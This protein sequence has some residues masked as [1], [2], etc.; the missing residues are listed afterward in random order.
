MPAALTANDTNYWKEWHLQKINAPSAWDVSTG[1]AGVVIAI[2]DSGIDSTHPDLAAKI[3]AGYNA[4]DNNSDTSDV[5]GHGTMVA[6]SAG[7]IS[8]NGIGVASVAWQNPLMPIRVTDTQGNGYASTIAKGLTWA[9]DHGARVMNI[10]FSGIAASSTITSAAQYVVGKGGIVVAASGNCGCADPTPEN[11]YIIS[12][13]A[14]NTDDTL[15]SFSSTG[16]Y[17]DV[18][19]PGVSIQTTVQGGGYSSVSGTSFASPI[20]AGVLALMMS[21]NPA[22]GPSD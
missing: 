12:V 2:L 4:Y 6:G 7:A 15:A 3:V 22:L 20:T 19:A 21:V 18:A 8:N 5:G 17:V 11:A 14:T 1:D 10:S 9:A 16:S 13:S